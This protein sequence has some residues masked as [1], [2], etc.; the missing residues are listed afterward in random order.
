MAISPIKQTSKPQKENLFRKKP[1]TKPVICYNEMKVQSQ[2]RKRSTNDFVYYEEQTMSAVMK[3]A[4]EVQ[5]NL[6]PQLPSMIKRML[7]SHVTGGFWLGLPKQFCDKHLPT[8]D[9]MIVLED[10]NGIEY[11]TKYLVSKVGL[12]A[13]WRG[14]SIA[15]NLVEGDMVVFQL[16][17]PTK[18]KVYIVRVKG[19][20]E[21]DGALGLLELDASAKPLSYR[22]PSEEIQDSM[23]LSMCEPDPDLDNK[24]ASSGN[25][26][27]ITDHSGS[28]EDDDV[29]FEVLD[30]IRLSDSV[31]DFN[32]VKRFEDFEI[33][34]NG[35]VINS[36]VSKHLQSKYYDLCCTKKRYLHENL[37]EGL[38]CKLAAGVIAETT[39][40]ADAI[41]A[42][43]PTT[44]NDSFTTW[45]KTLKAFKTLGMNVDFLIERLD[46]LINLAAKSRKYEQVKSARANAQEE[47]THLEKK[48]LELKQ[49]TARLDQQLLEMNSEDYD[50]IFEQVAKAAW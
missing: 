24:M 18:L 27:L 44:P 17:V 34:L 25:S 30:G 39:N 2:K 33:L 11:Q 21:L 26:E 31:I 38:N 20:D 49:V 41:R 47:M 23:P 3:R 12:S 43:K 10:E 9:T 16:V 50:L 42:S 32:Q 36:E 6:A 4:E 22:N 40:I 46:Q 35:L 29:G 13:G 5:A 37:L 48:L 1:S 15:H 8:Q 28:E 14:F 19:S 45:R 7:P